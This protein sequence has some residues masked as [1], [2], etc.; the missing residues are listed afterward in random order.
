MH[1]NYTFTR[2]NQN[3]MTKKV[4]TMDILHRKA[5]NDQEKTQKP[6]QSLKSQHPSIKVE[7]SNRG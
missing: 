2:P 1:A 3:D 7:N 6:V 5:S 4:K